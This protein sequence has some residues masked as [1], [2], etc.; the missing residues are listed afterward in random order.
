MSCTSTKSAIK[1]I[2]LILLIPMLAAQT[3]AQ[4]RRVPPGGRLAV[5]MD[6]RLAALRNA[7]DPS[8]KLMHRLSRG[9]LVAVLGGLRSRDGLTFLQVAITRRTRG[10]IQTEAVIAPWRAEDDDRSLRLIR[11]SEDFDRIVRTRLFLDAFPRSPLRPQGLL[12]FGDAA[13]EAAEK[14]SREAGRR[15]DRNEMNSGG[16]PEYSY[17]LNYNGLDRYNRQDI[18]FTFDR[19]T[20]TFHYDG[21]AWLELLRRYPNSPEAIEARR[22]L[23][24]LPPR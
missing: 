24:A 22:R 18:T 2:I 13:A 3:L 5:V 10:W 9:R 6:E 11:S 7:P 16:A 1:P 8:A 23:A 14:L 15:L 12:I 21:A 20:R 17:F 4:K 19:T